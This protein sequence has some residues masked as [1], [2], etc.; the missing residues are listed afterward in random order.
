M[1]VED[2]ERAELVLVD[3]IDKRLTYRR[4]CAVAA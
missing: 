3:A 4:T 1:G 2:D